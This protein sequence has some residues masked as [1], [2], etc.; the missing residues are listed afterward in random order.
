MVWTGTVSAKGTTAVTFVN[1]EDRGVYR[2]AWL[3]VQVVAEKPTLIQLAIRGETGEQSET[4]Y[5]PIMPVGVVPKTFFVK[6]PRQN[7]Y[8]EPV[9]T[10]GTSH[11][12]WITNGGSNPLLYTAVGLLIQKVELNLPTELK[13]SGNIEEVLPVGSRG[14][15]DSSTTSFEDVDF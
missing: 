15:I 8:W 12:G 9:G 2:C 5:S 6:Q 4:N 3:K 10:T 7:G 1:K 14:R 13:F 11:F